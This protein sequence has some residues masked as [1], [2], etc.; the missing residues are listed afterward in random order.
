MPSLLH[1]Q[2]HLLNSTWEWG[3]GWNGLVESCRLDRGRGQERTPLSVTVLAL[4]LSIVPDP[5]LL[6]D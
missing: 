1:L 4:G 6:L 5:L 3:E 2:L